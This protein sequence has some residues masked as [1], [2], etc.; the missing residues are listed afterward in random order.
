MAGRQQRSEETVRRLLAAAL[1]VYTEDGPEGFTMRAVTARSG[2]SVGSLYHHFGSF[3][4]LAN[5]LYS[6]C[7]ADLL[8]ALIAALEKKRT[9]RAG[10]E[11]T[12]RAYLDFVR[13]D[14]AEARFIHGSPYMGYL[15]A[16]AVAAVKAPRIEKL[17]AWLRPHIDA[18]AVADLPMP[19]IEMLLIGPVAEVT[20]RWIAGAPG[21][22]LDEAARVLP[23]PIWRSLS[24]P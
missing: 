13:T 11:A 12:V 19:L 4:G 18:G 16:G 1:D 8:D 14:P 3:D 15:D 5:A 7:M 23:G 2:V 9:A 24:P 22:D 20:R 10:V 17:V 6:E 21:I